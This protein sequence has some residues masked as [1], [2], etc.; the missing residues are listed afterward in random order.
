M[1]SGNLPSTARIESIFKVAMVVAFVLFFI[2]GAWVNGHHRGFSDGVA[3]EK[4][5]NDL[6]C[7]W[8]NEAYEQYKNEERQV[9]FHMPP[10]CVGVRVAP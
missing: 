6:G 4:S 9:A 2:Y 8:T 10:I 7:K 3:Y 1:T 5:V